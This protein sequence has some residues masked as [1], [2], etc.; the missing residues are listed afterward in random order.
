MSPIALIVSA[1]ANLLVA[2]YVLYRS[3]RSR[4]HQTFFLFVLGTV[5]WAGGIGA[6]F[7]SG[8][9]VFDKLIF[10]GAIVMMVGVVLFTRVFPRND[11]IPGWYR[12]AFIPWLV[13]L[14]TLPFNLLVSRIVVHTDGAI[15]PING[16]MMPVF[17]AAALAYCVLAV[18]NLLRNYREARGRERTQLMY[19]FVG[20]FAVLF[21]AAF[22]S[23]L[24]PSIGIFRFNIL[25][26]FS[27]VLFVLFVGYAIVRHE[28]L[29]IKIV[30]QRGTIYSLLFALLIGVYASFARLFADV[31]RYAT[32][33]SAESAAIVAL[34]IGVVVFPRLE[35]QFEKLTDRFFFKDRYRYPDVLERLGVVLGSSLTRDEIVAGSTEILLGAFRAVGVAFQFAED[36]VDV[37]FVPEISIPIHL[38]GRDYAFLVLGPKRSGDPY[39]RADIQ[40]LKTFAAQASLAFHRARLYGQVKEY[41]SELEAR[42]RER[43]AEV[44]RL[45]EQERRTIAE[46]SHA[47]QTPL[48]VMKGELSILQKEFPA[49]RGL[50]VFEKAIDG[51]STF[52]YD[53]LALSSLESTH[54]NFATEHVDMSAL[55]HELAEGYAIVAEDQNIVF[56]ASVEPG[57]F[58]LGR[59][60]ALSE[61]AG[62]L[63]SNAFKYM[64]PDAPE[65]RVLL[66]LYSEGSRI[67]LDV[68][69]TGIGMRAQDIDALFTRGY[70]I[71]DP[72]FA[73]VRGSGLGLLIARKIAEKHGGS[74]EVV[75]T[76]IDEGSL[77]RVELPRLSHV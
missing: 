51:I 52:I 12:Y 77:L 23:T 9:F 21:S 46:V 40:L 59:A 60:D 33:T 34:L 37:S 43:T 47:L 58:V 42:V 16:P 31:L 35:R 69:D 3:P 48:T 6:M 14:C 73:G 56:Q 41:S 57:L 70:R 71:R 18:T 25:G 74:V 75:R 8:N 54:E 2:C 17:V 76:A 5:L 26:P 11:S 24:L 55:V 64:L 67:V 66:M 45:Q 44:V 39:Q 15:E 7:A 50:G 27:T 19:L 62:N 61:L 28:L 36:A 29:D 68:A 4:V 20:S 72:R 22:F 65:R 53:L 38:D 13:V 30:I 10:V 63:V 32:D 49:T 1:F